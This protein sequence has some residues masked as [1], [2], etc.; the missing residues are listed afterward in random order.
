[1]RPAI[2]VALIFRTLDALRIF[3]LPYV[4]TQGAGR[5]PRVAAVACLY[6]VGMVVT[7]NATT[8]LRLP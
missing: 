7:L 5:A 8:V 3:D 1:L 2:L 4:L 6:T